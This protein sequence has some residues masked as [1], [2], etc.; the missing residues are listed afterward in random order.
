[1]NIF[2]IAVLSALLLPVVDPGVDNDPYADREDRIDSTVVSASRAGA[3][4]PVT[5]TMVQGAEL[6]KSSPLNSLP[7][8]LNLQPSVVSV[9]EGG[10][11]IGYSKMTVRGSKGSQINVTLNGVTLN[12]AESQEV[13]WVNIPSLGNVLSSVQL[14]RGLGT[15]A[16]GAG[17]F[18]ASINMS[19]ASVGADPYVNFD[20]SAGSYNSFLSSVAAG[21]GLMKNG[22]YIDAAY[23][24]NYTDGYIDNA[25]ARA[26]SALAVLG[27]MNEKNS[28]RL[29]W[30]MGDQHTGITWNGISLSQMEENRR[31]NPAGEYYDALGNIHRYANDTDNYTQNHLQLNYTHQFPHNVFWTTTFNWTNG[32]GWYE[33]YKYKKKFSKYG[34]TNDEL[35]ALGLPYSKGDKSDFIIRKAMLNNYYVANSQVTWKGSQVSVVGGVNYS[36]YDGD[37]YGELLWNSLMG[38]SFDYSVLDCSNSASNYWYYSNGLKQE[39]NVFAR[40]EYTPLDWLTAYVD[41]QYRGV[42]LNMSGIDD[43]DDAPLDYK[44]NWQFFNP[45][46]G[47]TFSMGGHKAYA[48]AALGHREP[49]R[50][51]I[52]EII[53]T[54]NWGGSKQELRPEKM[55]D[56][57][58]GYQYTSPVFTASANV[59]LME[60]WDMLLETGKLS[61]VG[62]A[63]KENVGRSFRRGIE[64]AAAYRPAPWVTLEG[65]LTLSLNKIKDYTAYFD[66]YDSIDT[67]N[68]AA[69]QHTEHFESTNMLMSPSIVGMAQVSFTPFKTIANNSLKTTTLTINA[70]GVGKQYWDNTSNPDHVIPAYYVCNL[71]L[72][73]EFSLSK[74]GHSAFGGSHS[75]SHHGSHDDSFSAFGHDGS[76]LGLGLYVNNFTNNI[77]FADAWGYN[78]YFENEQL[79]YSEEGVFPQ[80]PAN[81]MF[82]LYFRF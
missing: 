33:E 23:S 79:L 10:T 73:H 12:D 42:F 69:T 14:Q 5:Y 38:D 72:T 27:W 51:D 64:L 2:S 74:L 34:F 47:L 31:Y 32:N 29:T 50:A 36:L 8:S 55:L 58:L 59:Y 3:H 68:P 4:T 7:M 48:S 63:I 71:A 19:T 76:A 1:M 44:T 39:A 78:A 77:Y 57:E 13:F 41:L 56:I 25:F 82:K 70:K 35:T 11:G 46:A 52:K 60:Y 49:G 40:A 22:L 26:Q 15:S 61:D 20:V 65:N 9:N 45:R 53:I 62:Y 37:H 80:A 81:F 67:W 16:C 21:T 66:T 28:L 17:A 30:L 18:G 54:N 75:A 43:E 6:R 24:R